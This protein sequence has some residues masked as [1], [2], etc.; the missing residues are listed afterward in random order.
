MDFL[1]SI[2][3]DKQLSYD[4][5]VKA[6]EAHNKANKDEQ[7]KIANLAGG[8]Y[9]SKEKFDAKEKELTKANEQITS[10]NDTVKT[11]EGEKV[12][13]DTKMKELDKQYKKEMK[14]MQEGFAK[15]KAVNDWFAQNKTN[16]TD[17]LKSKFDMDKITVDGDKVIGLEE[18]G[19]TL[20]EQYKDLFVPVVQGPEPINPPQGFKVAGFA[21]LVRN[22]DN[23]SAEEIAA[24]FAEL[25]SN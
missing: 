4:E 11:F 25:E 13:L 12:E 9:V 19:E 24:Q 5:L 10:L 17:L 8:E 21:D 2:F 20:L 14:D 23:M 18:Q 22:A 6:V 15:E 16:Y 3:G 1:K 7:I